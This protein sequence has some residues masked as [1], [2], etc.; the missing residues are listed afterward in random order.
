MPSLTYPAHTTIITGVSPVRH[1]IL[2]N[3]PFD[4]FNK[5]GNG[6]YWYA[7]DIKIETLWD[8]ATKAGL[9]TG[10]VEWPVAVG[11]NITYNIPQYWRGSGWDNHKILK[12]V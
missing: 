10:N 7:D 2:S 9:V 3:K 8:K 4:P 11:A 5:N 1:G 12:I 6:W